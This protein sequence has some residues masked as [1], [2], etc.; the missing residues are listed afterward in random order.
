MGEWD[1]LDKRLQRTSPLLS[2]DD[3]L[4]SSP[5]R[6]WHVAPEF[7]NWGQQSNRDCLHEV[8]IFV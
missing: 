5:N 4:D 2:C 6:G 7:L 3:D 1:K 8:E